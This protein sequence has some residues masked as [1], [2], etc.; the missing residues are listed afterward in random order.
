VF[1]YVYLDDWQVPGVRSLNGLG[2][3]APRQDITLRAARHGA[4]DRTLYY[5]GR[6]LELQGILWGATDLE[7]WEALDE[8][9]GKLALGSSHV[10]R[11]R[12]TG[13]LN[14]EQLAIIVAGPVDDGTSYDAPGVIKYGVSLHAPDPRIY[15]AALRSGS[16]DPSAALEGA[17]AAVPLVFPLD[18]SSSG[19]AGLLELANGGNFKTPPVL[20]ITGPVVNPIIDN[21]TTSESLELVYSLGSSDTVEVDIAARTVTLNGASRPDLLTPQATTWW[22]LTPGT[23]ELRLRGTGMALGKTAL[24]AA[25]RD[26]RI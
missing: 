11:F 13:R 16:Y 26:A 4:I 19:V 25:W 8:L 10:L 12:R 15:V 20:T 23:N 5:G 24:T 6:V 14:D 9:K 2:S 18:F 3:P 22:E 1:D 7:A 17:G 21:V